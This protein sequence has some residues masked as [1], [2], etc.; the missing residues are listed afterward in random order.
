LFAAS[1][2]RARAKAKQTLTNIIL[3]AATVDARHAEWLLE[4][5]FPQEFGRTAERLLLGEDAKQAQPIINVI[6]REGEETRRAERLA[7]D[8]LPHGRK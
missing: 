2:A 4:R 3:K 5:L 7:G 8:A 6:I 1:C